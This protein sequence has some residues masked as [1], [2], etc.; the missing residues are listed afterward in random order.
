[1]FCDLNVPSENIFVVEIDCCDFHS[2]LNGS[3][4]ASEADNLLPVY[5]KGCIEQS[6]HRIFGEIGGHTTVDV[7]KF[8]EK[9]HRLILRVPEQF[10]VKLRAALTLIDQFQGIP[11]YFH[12]QSATRV[13]LALLDTF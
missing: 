11:C 6:L 4:L 9:R 3:K 12:V 13:L 7:L 8:D 2:L 1:M 5:V 10:Y